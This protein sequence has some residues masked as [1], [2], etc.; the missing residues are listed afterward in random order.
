MVSS[1]R[2][3][4]FDANPSRAQAARIREAQLE[5]Y[6]QIV[7]LQTRH[8]LATRPRERWTALWSGNPEY[9]ESHGRLPIGWVLE[10]PSGEVVGFL[11]NVPLAYRFDGQRVRAATAYSWAVDLQYRSGSVVL[12]DRFLRQEWVD[13]FV[14]TTVN[15]AAEPVLQAFQFRRAPVGRW[16][17][18][19]FWITSRRGFSR[20][21]LRAAS[22]SFP[23]LG[24][25][26]QALAF[27]LSIRDMCFSVQH[28]VAS[29]M[30][31]A[32]AVSF[33]W[34]ECK[35][36]DER[37]DDFWDTLSH[38]KREHLIAV[39]NRAALEWHYR[40]AVADNTAWVLTACQEDRLV[41]YAVFDRR[42]H[43]ELGLMRLRITD[44]QALAGYEGLFHAALDS[45]LRKCRHEGVHIV[46]NVG[47]WLE[48]SALPAVKAPYHRKMKSWLFY[49]KARQ[50]GLARRLEDP[51]V[52][53]V[54]SYDGDASIS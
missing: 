6:G 15:A 20:S 3:A 1:G 39:R 46:E 36:F 22:A 33:E 37:F 28:R 45:M 4:T 49:Y 14:F 32:S 12:L 18:S 51:K 41:A 44:F 40:R 53:A 11:G 24:P 2:S 38:E 25:S 9:L 23:F 21:A 17:S 7:A 31:R 26:A 13:L 30:R 19:A 52:W 5:D 47:C 27:V 35:H 29:A 48:R 8:H 43:P 54:S 34:K 50:D 42:D 16:D 10:A